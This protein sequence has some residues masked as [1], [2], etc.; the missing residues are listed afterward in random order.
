MSS[1]LIKNGK[2]VTSTDTFAADIYIEGETISK[3]GQNLD[4]S[5][6][7]TIDATGRLIF[8]GG[9][10]PHVHL[11]LHVAGAVSSDDYETGTRAALF[12][13]TTTV[14]DFANQAKGGLL[15]E[16]LETWKNR[17]QGNA[18]CDYSFHIAI[19]DF[20][21]KTK[22]EIGHLVKNEG[23]SSFKTFMAYKGTMMIDD[24]QMLGIMEEVKK[25]QGLVSVHATNGDMIDYLVEKFKSKK[26]LSPRYHYLSQ[27][28]ITETEA[29]GRFTDLAFLTGVNGYIVHTTC[30]GVLNEIRRAA[31]RGQKVLV[32][33]C[34]QYLLLDASLYTDD[35]GSA[36]WVMSPPLR[37]EKDRNALWEGLRQ[38]VIQTVGTDHCPFM[39]KDKLQGIDDFTKIPNGTPGI[40]HRIEL[41]FSEG[42]NKK[43]ITLNRFVEVVATNPAKIF[44]L[45]PKKGTVA[46]GSDADLVVFDPE[47][48]HILSAGTHHHRCDYSAYEGFKVTGKVS[49]VFLRGK[50]VIDNGSI[51]IKK[52]YGKFL[53]RGV[54][55]IAE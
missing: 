22:A 18:F 51:K 7:R 11:R 10:D 12:G 1:I 5:A 21:E 40:E 2:I 24:S 53:K 13:G 28:E 44:G 54:P 52:G 46:V 48:K 20:N 47:E 41:L 9:V 30:E 33:T 37:M 27:P 31:K 15:S 17:A 29:A 35:I 19:T 39:W 23:I 26:K 50:Q 32:E 38:G 42:V 34:P 45:F 49:S 25:H 36:R 55:E 43:R 16:A 4:V 6:G 14:I 3:I 8:P